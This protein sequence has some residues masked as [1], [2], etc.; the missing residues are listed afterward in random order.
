MPT[1]CASESILLIFYVF[2][3]TPCI[4]IHTEKVNAVNVCCIP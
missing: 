3:T 4:A 2:Y 1:E